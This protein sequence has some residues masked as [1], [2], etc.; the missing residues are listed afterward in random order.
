VHSKEK[1]QVVNSRNQEKIKA[2][3]ERGKRA[4]NIL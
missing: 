2:I 3:A 4:F 1:K